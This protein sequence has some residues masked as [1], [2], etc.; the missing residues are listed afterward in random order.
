[1][2]R[3]F[4]P[5]STLILLV[6][7]ILL[8]T[9]AY[10]AVSY[11]VL[12][13]DP[14][15][16]LFYDNGLWA[17]LLVTLGIVTGLYFH[18]L[19]SQIR[20]KSRLL[21]LQ[22]LC[23][24]TGIVFLLEGLIS[25]LSPN[26]RV[27]I[28][29]MLLGSPLAVAAIFVWRIFFAA[30]AAQVIDRERLLLV[31]GSPLLEDIGR[32]VAE[33]PASGL[34]VAGC[35]AENGGREAALPEGEMPG[36]LGLLPEIVQAT[37]PNRIVLGMLGRPSPRFAAELL[38]LR[39]AGHAV[40]EAASTYERLYGRVCLKGRRPAQF[41]YSGAFGPNS[42]SL[43]SQELWNTAAAF[44]GAIGLAP[45]MLLTALAVWLSSGGPIL[46]RQVRAGLGGVR[47]TMYRFRTRADSRADGEAGW[48]ERIIR[49][50]HLDELPQLFN[51]LKGEMSIVG[52]HP[53]RPEFVE[54]LSAR[55]PCYR[56]RGCVRPGMTGWAQINSKGGG[57]VNDTITQLEYDLYYIDNMS[58]YLD[59]FVILSTIKAMLLPREPQ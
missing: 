23:L 28:R 3:V 38:Q 41:I 29:V 34:L 22:Q 9:S 17:L 50:F 46:C 43:S 52:P 30:F 59:I 53:E 58:L 54:A 51:V 47:F 4:I 37:S 5:V 8:I 55:I 56:H 16:Y 18:D 45:V 21:L 15:D 44:L 6:S 20:V 32:Y 49:R 39:F 11:L 19:Y 27:P 57:A 33:H 36:R 26:L 7:E 25:Y 40:E 1:M 42:K 24:T 31:G 2:G 10:V 48:M 35:V 14:D 12:E 13:V